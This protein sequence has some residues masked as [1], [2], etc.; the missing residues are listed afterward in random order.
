MFK[1]NNKDTRPTSLTSFWCLSCKLWTYFIPFS[2]IPI[3]DLEQVNVR[4]DKIAPD[5]NCAGKIIPFPKSYKHTL[6]SHTYT[7]LKF[8]GIVHKI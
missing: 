1:V 2:R 8:F 3:A 5:K 4:L 7:F 6:N